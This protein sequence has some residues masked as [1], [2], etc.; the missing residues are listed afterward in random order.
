[1]WFKNLLIYRFKETVAIDPDSLEHSLQEFKFSPCGSQD[2]SKIGFTKAMGKIG[3]SLVHSANNNHLIC[4]TK[5]DK[6]LPA[7][8]IKEE[9]ETKVAEIEERDARPLRKQEKDALKDDITQMLLPRAFTKR[10]QTRALIMPE[11][12]LIM[13]DASSSNKAEEVLALLRKALGSLP[14]LPLNYV[15]P[16]DVQLTSWLE[17]GYAPSPFTIG[18]EAELKSLS[19][20]GAMVKFKNQVLDDDEVTAHIKAGKVVQKLAMTFGES[21]DFI[22]AHDCSIKRLKFTDLIRGENDLLGNDDPMARLDADFALMVGELASLANALNQ[23]LG[24]VD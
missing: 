18:E 12:G 6:I 15:E 4:V 3:H 11:A 10:S 20:D 7:A 8:V 24:E 16:V 14:I 2:V 23:A 17:Q 13:V 19:E 21:S 5:E 22:F 1:M 9:L